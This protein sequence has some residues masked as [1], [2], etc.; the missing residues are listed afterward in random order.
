M[1]VS[2][3]QVLEEPSI[4]LKVGEVFLGVVVSSSFVF[5]IDRPE[6]LALHSNKLQALLLMH[7][8]AI[9]VMRLVEP[10]P[11]NT[12]GPCSKPKCIEQNEQ[13]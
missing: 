6:P 11:L 9:H 10:L 5:P 2:S 4:V 12:I 13:K 1:A 7:A 8:Q 3:R